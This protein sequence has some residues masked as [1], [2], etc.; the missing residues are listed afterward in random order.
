MR[1][2]RYESVLGEWEK[3]STYSFSALDEGKSSVSRFGH[4]ISGAQWIFGLT[5]LQSQSG[6]GNKE[7]KHDPTGKWNL[8]LL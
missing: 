2:Q 7:S 3:N 8:V 6:S 5:D 4:L 1:T